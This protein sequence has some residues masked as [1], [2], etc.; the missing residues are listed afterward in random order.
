[1]KMIIIQTKDLYHAAYIRTIG[2]KVIEAEGSYPNVLFTLEINE[3]KKR[4]RDILRFIDW[5][6]FKKNRVHLKNAALTGIYHKRKLF[7]LD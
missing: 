4:I 3:R 5:K 7:N 6:K 1:M 2:G